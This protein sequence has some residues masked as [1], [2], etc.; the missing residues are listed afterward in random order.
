[1]LAAIVID[2]LCNTIRSVDVGVVYIYFNYKM[3]L[4]QTPVYLLPAF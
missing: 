3:Q 4:D 1:M 2:H